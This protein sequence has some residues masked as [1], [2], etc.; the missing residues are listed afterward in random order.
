MLNALISGAKVWINIP[1]QYSN[2]DGPLAGTITVQVNSDSGFEMK[3]ITIKFHGEAE[4]EYEY[5]KEV[6]NGDGGKKK[7]KE[8]FKKEKKFDKVKAM[9][10]GPQKLTKGTH[11]FPF[12][13]QLPEN[14]P[15]TFKLKNKK[16][17]D[18]EAEI[19]YKMYAKIDKAG[20]DPKSEKVHVHLL[21]SVQHQAADLSNTNKFMFGKGSSTIHVDLPTLAFPLGSPMELSVECKNE[22]KKTNKHLKAKLQQRIKLIS[23]ERGVPDMVIN[24]TVGEGRVDGA[25]SQRQ[26]VVRDLQIHTAD[27]PPSIDHKFIQISYKLE[28]A[29]SYSFAKDPAVKTDVKLLPMSEQRAASSPKSTVPRMALLEEQ[30]QQ[31]M[32]Q[33]RQQQQQQQQAQPDAI[34]LR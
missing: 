4:I 16:G 13:L 19:E 29:A 5:M 1:K 34:P 25:G 7:E 32:D 14:L 18:Y 20:L 28:V 30:Q 9:V 10:V 26:T 31:Q 8:K 23:G 21:P 2:G 3:G 12:Q 22:S 33:Q 11:N 17:L 24:R 27:L 6:D 15:A